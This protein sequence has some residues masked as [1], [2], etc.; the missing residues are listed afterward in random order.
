MTIVVNFFAGAGTGKT[1]LATDIFSRL[2]KLNVETELAL[3]FAKDLVWEENFNTLKNQ[4]YVFGHQLHR[5][6]RLIGKVDV[7][8]TDSPLLLSIIYRPEYLSNVFDKLVLEVF[9]SYNNLNYFIERTHNY[10][11][12]GRVEKTLEEASIKDN[13][14]RQ[15]LINNNITYKSIVGNEEYIKNIIGSI[16]EK[17]K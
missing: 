6:E 16:I 9:N 15:L 8:I 13:Q 10:N 14:I 5:I 17:V 12:N 7:V 2:K 1:T 3:E 11:P 4:M